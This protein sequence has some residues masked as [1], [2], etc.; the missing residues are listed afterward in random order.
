MEWKYP[1]LDLKIPTNMGEMISSLEKI[2]RAVIGSDLD[3]NS[4]DNNFSI[5]AREN[6]EKIVLS[7]NLSNGN[8]IKVLDKAYRDL[9]DNLHATYEWNTE[10]IF[11]VAA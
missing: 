11:R 4:I 6:P 2:T 7:L 8:V 1:E 5:Y 10:T 9:A 3:L